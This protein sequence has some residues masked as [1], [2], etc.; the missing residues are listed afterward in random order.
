[1]N[2]VHTLAN[3]VEQDGPLRGGQIGRPD[4]LGRQRHSERQVVAVKVEEV[5]VGQRR[6]SNEGDVI[7][8]ASEDDSSAAALGSQSFVRPTL[9]ITF[10]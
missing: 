4:P 5:F 6:R 9:P 3:Q 2:E 10:W 7:F 1:M 8:G